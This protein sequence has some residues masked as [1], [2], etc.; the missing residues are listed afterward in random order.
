MKYARIVRNSITTSEVEDDPPHPELMITTEN[1]PL[2][3]ST[4]ARRHLQVG[5]AASFVNFS[6]WALSFSAVV[7]RSVIFF[8]SQLSGQKNTVFF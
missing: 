4:A 3:T 2:I 6:T 7:C 1:V 8:W 5:P